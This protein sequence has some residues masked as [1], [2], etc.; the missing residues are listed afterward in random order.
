M[1]HLRPDKPLTEA[2]LAMANWAIGGQDLWLR[3]G[4]VWLSDEPRLHSVD[5]RTAVAVDLPRKLFY[6]EHDPT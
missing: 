3:D 4:R 6:L 1:P 5:A 2:E